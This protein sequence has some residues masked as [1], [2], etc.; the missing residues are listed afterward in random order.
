MEL[1][2]ETG[3]VIED[4]TPRIFDEPARESFLSIIANLVKACGVPADLAVN[5]TIPLQL[6]VRARP[7]L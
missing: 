4:G 6:V 1:F 2:Q 7:D 3:F 5:D